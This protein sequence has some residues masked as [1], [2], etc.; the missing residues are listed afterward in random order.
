MQV[1][2][3]N[4]EHRIDIVTE[5]AQVM[6]E[7]NHFASEDIKKRLSLL[8]DHWNHLKEKSIQRK[9]DLEDSLQVTIYMKNGHY[10]QSFIA[11]R[12]N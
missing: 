3:N 2:I 9:K 6:V 5:A 7:S 8:H 10:K 12:L 1:E 11:F 4:H